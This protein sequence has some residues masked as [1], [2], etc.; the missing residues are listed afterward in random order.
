MILFGLS[1]EF[2]IRVIISVIFIIFI[3]FF[4]KY[5]DKLINKVFSRIDPSLRLEVKSVFSY[6][7]YVLGA[8]I[9]ISIISPQTSILDVI[10]LLLGLAIVISFADVLRN[11][12]IQFLLRGTKS[13]KI[14]DWIEVDGIF[15]RVISIEDNGIFLETARR[16]R[17]FISNIRLIN[18]IIINRTTPIGYMYRVRIY[19]PQTVKPLEALERVKEIVSKIK[20]ELSS[21]PTVLL[22]LEKNMTVVDLTMEFLNVYKLEVFSEKVLEEVLREFPEAVIKRI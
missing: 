14:G 19:I 21:E 1:N 13:F 5:L 12:G 8:L 7:I 4:V 6:V 17:I 15:G 18:S 16:E 11:W 10:I 3:Y 20:G 2:V 22:G 9:A